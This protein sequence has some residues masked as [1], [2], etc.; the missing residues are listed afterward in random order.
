VDGGC[1]SYIRHPTFPLHFVFAEIFVVEVFEPA[2]HFFAVDLV[3]NTGLTL[4]SLQDFFVDEYRAINAE[5]ER[6]CIAGTRIDRY[7]GS[8]SLDPDQRV[9]CVFF[10]PRDDHLMDA[11]V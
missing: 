2:L 6:K 11:G 8:I 10:D 5:G 7:K 4:G 3:L 1:G 9:E